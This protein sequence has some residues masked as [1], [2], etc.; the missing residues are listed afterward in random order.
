[1]PRFPAVLSRFRRF[2]A[3]PGRPGQ[4]L[5]VPA[6]GDDAAA[7]LG[8]LLDRLEAV[9]AQAGQIEERAEADA[10]RAHERSVRERSAILEQGRMRAEAE[11]VR[12]AADQR[13]QAQ[14]AGEQARAAARREADRIRA[15]RD[16]VVGEMVQEVVACVK[17]TGR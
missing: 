11:R 8:P 4:A 16:A 15:R 17:R 3:P 7:E 14:R 2:L 9:D 12:A 6:T 13:A 5:G 1:V 10:R